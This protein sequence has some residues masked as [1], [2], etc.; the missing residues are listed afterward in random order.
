M[1]DRTATPAEPC[2]IFATGAYDESAIAAEIERRMEGR[3]PWQRDMIAAKVRDAAHAQRWP[4]VERAVEAEWTAAED[5]EYWRLQDAKHATG[6]SAP[7]LAEWDRIARLQ[8]K[9]EDAVKARALAKI[10]APAP[11]LMQAAE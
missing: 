2:L 8:A 10:D 6:V 11:A 1:F 3:E 7:G 4:F 9:L 5:A